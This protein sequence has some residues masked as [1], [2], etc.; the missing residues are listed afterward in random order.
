MTR[1][2]GCGGSLLTGCWR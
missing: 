1:T 2:R